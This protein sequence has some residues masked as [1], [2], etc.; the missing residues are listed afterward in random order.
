MNRFLEDLELPRREPPFPGAPQPE[1]MY[2]AIWSSDRVLIKKDG[3]SGSP[4]SLEFGG[5]AMLEGSAN[6]GPMR[7]RG[8]GP[9]E[10]GPGYRAYQRGGPGGTTIQVARRV[11]REQ[12]LMR[13][14]ALRLIGG[15]VGVLAVGLLGGWL[16]SKR[17]LDPINEI[18]ATAAG[19]SASNL[20]KRID[21]A[22]VDTELVGLSTTLNETFGRLEQA[23]AQLTRFTSD[24]SH[25]L[26]TPL[27][28]LQTHAELALARPREAADYRETIETC[29]RMGQ[30]MSHLVE[31]LLTLARADA[32]KLEL[33]AQPVELAPLIQ[34]TVGM[35]RP[36]AEEKKVILR[37]NLQPAKIDGDPGR[38]AQVVTNLISNA[39]QYNHAG[40]AVDISLSQVEGAALLKI[41]DTGVGIPAADQPRVFERFFRV[42]A[43]RARDSGGNGLGLAICK[44]IIE[45]HG[46]AIGFDSSP[47]R[48]TTFWIRLPLANDTSAAG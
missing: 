9:R 2:F 22:R 26:R 8:T 3:L 5:F 7:I 19:I 28:I 27:T 15:A 40:G 46:G 24:A 34:E 45:A 36:I 18:A 31:G 17:I 30:R 20:S 29:L 12:G 41:S 6:R 1:P 21:T 33:R 13:S 10:L 23:F 39:I 37:A 42:D 38:I 47:G 35:F 16:I 14:W 48:G 11:E 25:E 4:F 44:S 43:A 32:G